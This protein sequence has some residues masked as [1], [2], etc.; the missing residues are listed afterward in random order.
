MMDRLRR[1]VGTP[2]VDSRLPAGV[3]LVRGSWIPAVGG[4]LSGMGGPAA[5]VTLGSTIVVRPGVALEDRLLRH[6]LAHVRQ[7]RQ[8][9]L[10]FPL[11]YALGHVRHGY[12]NNPYEVEARAAEGRGERSEP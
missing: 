11:L 10:A 1:L 9:P 8:R 3:A 12:R 7:W 4:W 2:V 5:A 6:E